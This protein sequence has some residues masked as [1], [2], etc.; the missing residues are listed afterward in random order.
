MPGSLDPACQ[1]VSVSRAV[2]CLAFSVAGCRGSQADAPACCSFHRNFFTTPPSHHHAYR[3][4]RARPSHRTFLDCAPSVCCLSP[5]TQCSGRDWLRTP[6]P[7]CQIFQILILWWEVSFLSLILIFF[8]P[9]NIATTFFFFRALRQHFFFQKICYEADKMPSQA[10]STPRTTR[11]SRG[12]R[13][14]PYPALSP[15]PSSR[16]SA[17]GPAPAP[18]TPTPRSRRR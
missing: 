8:S 3:R 4:A 11:N 10:S 5:N 6:R 12:L 13:A 14:S 9:V 18:S 7:P 2:P 17:A 16:C 1:R 15:L